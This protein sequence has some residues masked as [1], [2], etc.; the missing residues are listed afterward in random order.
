MLKKFKNFLQHPGFIRYFK[1]TS[2]LLVEK[3]L[4]IIAA[5]FIGAWVAKYLGPEN[6][7]ILSYAQSF[8]AIFAAFSSLGLKNIL[9]RELVTDEKNTYVLL[10]T[11]FLLQTIGSIV[12]ITCVGVSIYLNDN[13]P[14]TNK[15]I[16]ILG[17]LTFLNSFTVI[18]SYFQSIVR[19]KYVVIPSILGLI[20]SSIFKV[21]LIFMESP[22][23]HFVYILIFDIV[24]LSVG[25]LFFYH[26]N[27][28]SI[29]NWKFSSNKAI[30]LLKDSWPL[31]LSGI[32]ISIYMR[33]DQ[34]MIK[35]MMDNSSVGEYAAAVKLSEAWYFIPTVIAGSL[36]PAIINAKMKSE[37]L[38]RSRLQRLYD[39]MVLMALSLAIPITLLSDWIVGVFFGPEF[40]QTSSVL[41]IHIW[42]GVFVFL[43]V[44]NAKWFICENLQ[45]YSV[46]CLGIGMLCNILLNAILIPKYGIIG[47]AY[48]TLLSQFV[49]SFFTPILFKKTRPSFYMMMRSLFFINILKLKR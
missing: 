49:S 2:W 23:I 21:I 47:A 5:L 35:E 19:S 26:K 1:N 6:F 20:I 3:V 45:K 30:S 37:K 39:L 13:E 25:Q 24:L 40:V 48:A 8:V 7:G 46:V 34:V 22:L 11:S 12:L 14:L 4:R 27:G 38:Y 42:A 31:I 43:G 33:I 18:S 10:G 17:L 32:I 28:Q 15:I 36:F 9:T 16:I 44:S 41:S 29:L